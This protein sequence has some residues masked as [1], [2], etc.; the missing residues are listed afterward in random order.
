METPDK[1]SLDQQICI[2]S[3][4]QR[5]GTIHCIY[6]ATQNPPAQTLTTPIPP[7]PSLRLEPSS[8]PSLPQQAIGG[9]FS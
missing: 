6:D 2:Q 1:L 7:Q 3:S 8:I 5:T 9:R 4:E